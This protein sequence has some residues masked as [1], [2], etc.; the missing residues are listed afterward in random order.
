M[1]LLKKEFRL[2]MHPIAPM[3]LCLSALILV[4]AYPYAITCFYMTLAIFFTCLTSRENH[5][6]AYTACLPVSRRDMVRGRMLFSCILELVQLL[7]CLGFVFL[8]PLTGSTENS[9]G[10]DANIAV[11]A[12]GLIVFG[13]FNA[14]FFPRWYKDIT[15]VGVPFLIAGAAVFLY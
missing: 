2:C 5:D 9:A 7:V 10:M 8:R 3:M 1:N 14:L 13:L 11:T 6:A 4:P 12:E 15:K